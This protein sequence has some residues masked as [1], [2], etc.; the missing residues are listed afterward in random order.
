MGNKQLQNISC[1]RDKDL[2]LANA[3][4]SVD[5]DG[6]SGHLSSVQWLNYLGC[7]DVVFFE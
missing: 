2:F 1:L 3:K 7:F 6:T 4:S 5:L